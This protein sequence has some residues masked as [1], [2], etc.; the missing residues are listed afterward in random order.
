VSTI[1][2]RSTPRDQS[3]PRYLI[4]L[5][6]LLSRSSAH[7]SIG[8]VKSEFASV[9]NIV[10]QAEI[11]AVPVYFSYRAGILAQAGR[12]PRLSW[13][14]GSWENGQAPLYESP[15]TTDH[16]VSTHT[17]GLA[18]LVR[19]ILRKQ[20][21]ATIDLIGFSLGGIVALDFAARAE[22]WVMAAIER[23]VLISCP[24]GGITRAS[25]LVGNV[26]LRT[27]AGRFKFDFGTGEALADIAFGSPV[28]DR[29]ARGMQRVPVLSIEN[30]RDIV[31]S[32][33]SQKGSAVGSSTWRLPVRLGVGTGPS[34]AGIRCIRAHVPSV[35]VD[36]RADH[37][38]LLVGA[39]FEVQR[40]HAIIA[41]FL[42]SPVSEAQPPRPLPRTTVPEFAATRALWQS[43]SACA[44]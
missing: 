3:R 19:D 6:G 15:D 28:L 24:V 23:I 22:Q 31:V 41:S 17:V 25:H 34:R 1:G 37:R 14:N 12:D 30:E 7:P 38:C 32:A 2:P 21:D 27:V 44:I 16:R 40:A 5:D 13:I 35:G 10:R 43:L 39:G 18:F 8:D 36:I 9:W 33:T 29:V 4:F 42:K 11:A 26:L 20:P